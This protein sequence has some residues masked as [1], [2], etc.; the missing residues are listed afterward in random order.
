VTAARPARKSASLALVIAL[1]ALTAGG[2]P[3]T[4]T[5]V[6]TRSPDPR[7]ADSPPPPEPVRLRPVPPTRT[8]TRPAPTP[9][10]VRTAAR[11][12]AR[13]PDSAPVFRIPGD[14]GL[15]KANLRSFEV[16]LALGPS[17]RERYEIQL[18]FVDPVDVS[19]LDGAEVLDSVAVRGAPR[20]F[21]ERGLRLPF[22]SVTPRVLTLWVERSDA[23]ETPGVNSLVFL[24]LRIGDAVFETRTGVERR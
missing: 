8:E 19:G 5:P 18:A 23:L 3:V 10:P 13:P 11:P 1:S 2:T 21:L 20:A 14:H 24:K 7:N 6:P 9:P 17:G 22:R 15:N 4:P 12:T 16:R